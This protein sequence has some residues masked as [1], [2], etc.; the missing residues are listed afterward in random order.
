MAK[1]HAIVL[2][3]GDKEMRIETD[4]LQ[5]LSTISWFKDFLSIKE[6]QDAIESRDME[7]NAL[8]TR[9]REAREELSK[10]KAI[11]VDQRSQQPVTQQAPPQQQMKP[12][13]VPSPRPSRSFLDVAPDQMT[14]EI[15]ESFNADQQRQWSEIYLRQNQ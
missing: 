4:D 13:P 11:M 2:Q 10:I 12:A 7:I 9:L 6:S 3:S 1:K 8:R 14:R 15:W 5:D